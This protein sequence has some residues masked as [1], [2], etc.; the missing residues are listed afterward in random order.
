MQV[1]EICSTK[2]IIIRPVYF[3]W[4]SD[5]NVSQHIANYSDAVYVSSCSE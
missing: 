5:M 1:T 4:K 2:D 3:L